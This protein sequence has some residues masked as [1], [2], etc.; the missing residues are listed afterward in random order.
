PAGA[1]EAAQIADLL[2]RRAGSRLP[3]TLLGGPRAT[4]EAV[5]HALRDA[6]LIHFCGHSE[7]APPR[8]ELGAGALGPEEVA[9][10]PL[11]ARLVVAN[12][13]VSH[14][15]ARAFVLA[16]AQNYLGT[17]WRVADRAAAAFS[18]ALY[19]EL[20]LGRPLGEALSIARTALRARDPL[21][22]AAYVHYGDPDTRLITPQARTG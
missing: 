14:G 11:G 12:S 17:W 15:F 22:W 2:W 5:Q 21:H 9:L 10:R 3:A 19:E 13:C 4:S 16:G 8:W 6:S 1:A 7:A 20:V 18:L